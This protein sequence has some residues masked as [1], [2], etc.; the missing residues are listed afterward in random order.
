MSELGKTDG[1]RALTGVRPTGDLTLANYLGAIQP[2]VDMQ[3]TFVGEINVFVADIHGLTDQEPSKVQQSIISSAKS[4]VAVGV[5]PER[6]TVYLQSQIEEPTL[7]LAHMLDRHTTP[8]ELSRAPTLKDKIKD[9]SEAENVN[10]SVFR[11]PVLMAADIAIQ[12][13]THVP[14]GEDQMPHIEF[15]R[16]VVRRFNRAYGAGQAILTEPQGLART[17][18]RIAA[19]QERHGKMSKSQPSSALLLRDPPDEIARKIKK[20]QTGP[21]GQMPPILESHFLMAR[22]LSGE[23]S[24]KADIDRLKLAHM[25]GEVVM[26]QFK[27]ALTDIVNAFL[28]GY[29]ERYDEISDAEV[30]D[31]LRRGGQRVEHYAHDTAARARSALGLVSVL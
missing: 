12:A 1:A 21:A 13:A 22:L 2:I 17:P 15:T 29:R 6:S 5:D 10:M 28:H 24:Q 26:G 25:A 30:K 14:V 8:S 31:L 27:S 11:Y 18:I 16:H 3:D 7:W 19:L 23:D 20:A 9:S 4:L